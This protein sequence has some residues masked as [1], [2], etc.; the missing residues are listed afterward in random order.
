ME[1]AAAVSGMPGMWP[2]AADAHFSPA[3]GIRRF[4]VSLLDD[5]LS[6]S[7]S[8]AEA[9]DLLSSHEDLLSQCPTLEVRPRP[10][11]PRA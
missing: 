11:H 9:E 8:E 4:D 10:T 3:L 6:S 7:E 2:A 1:E 5:D